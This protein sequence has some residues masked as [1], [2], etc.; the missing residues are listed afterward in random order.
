MMNGRVGVRHLGFPSVGNV[1]F[2]SII[3]EI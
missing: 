2:S 3:E 1:A